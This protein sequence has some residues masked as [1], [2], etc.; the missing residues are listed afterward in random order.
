MRFN[1]SSEKEFSAWLMR[2]INKIPL[3]HAVRL[4]NSIG[5]GIPDINCCVGGAEVW[6]ETK[7]GC[8]TILL[9]KEQHAWITRRVVSGGVVFIVSHCPVHEMVAV[10]QTPVAVRK[11]G[12]YLE[13]VSG[14][15]LICER[16]A[17]NMLMKFLGLLK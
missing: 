16:S 14:F 4:E 1:I 5:A 13:I 17:T 8:Q 15:D 9:R 6:I 3:C 7:V 10:R 2:T 12:D 11:H